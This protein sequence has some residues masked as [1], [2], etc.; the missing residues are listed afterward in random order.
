MIISGREE[1]VQSVFSERSC[2]YVSVEGN[3]S[4]APGTDDPRSILSLSWWSTGHSRV[5]PIGAPFPG[6]LFPALAPPRGGKASLRLKASAPLALP[7]AFAERPCL[8]PSFPLGSLLPPAA[9]PQAYTMQ[10]CTG[11]CWAASAMSSFKYLPGPLPLAYHRVFHLV[12]AVF[13]YI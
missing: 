6:L 10:P 12:L 8:S 11:L 1:R 5:I 2:R 13:L 4:S 7:S 9:H 3:F